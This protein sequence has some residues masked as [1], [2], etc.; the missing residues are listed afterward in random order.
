MR[1]QIK[2]MRVRTKPMA[3]RTQERG[4]P[5]GAGRTSVDYRSCFTGVTHPKSVGGG[6]WLGERAATTEF[7]QH[8][9][10]EARAGKQT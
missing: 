2:E 5:R 6:N 10:A 8:R 4:Y 3:R 1:I 9:N 7:S